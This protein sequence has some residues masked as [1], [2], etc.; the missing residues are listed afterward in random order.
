MG[1]LEVQQQLEAQQC[2]AQL[3]A[4]LFQ[5]QLEVQQC[6]ARLE[7]QPPLEDQ[8]FLQQLFLA[9][10]VPQLL[11][12]QLQLTNARIPLVEG[13]ELKRTKINNLVYWL[14]YLNASIN[15]H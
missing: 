10:L 4:E 13:D 12:Q 1:F 9:Q 2:L 7:V 14:K 11:P 5:V 15:E 8:Q 6:L 3:E